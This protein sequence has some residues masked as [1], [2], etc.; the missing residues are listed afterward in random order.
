MN[1][2]IF[3]KPKDCVE[4]EALS[5]PIALHTPPHKLS[6]MH[7]FSATKHKHAQFF[8]FF[9]ISNLH[10]YFIKEKTK[11]KKTKTKTKKQK[12]NKTTR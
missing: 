10:L 5:S 6:S 3:L 2:F 12:Q 4:S 11:N 9:S 7:P 8:F 1:P